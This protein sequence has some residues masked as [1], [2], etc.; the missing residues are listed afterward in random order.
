MKLIEDFDTL[1][2]QG[3]HILLGKNPS[4]TMKVLFDLDMCFAGRMRR[5]SANVCDGVHHSMCDIWIQS[6]A[7]LNVAYPFFI[8]TMS[9]WLMDRVPFYSSFDVQQKLLFVNEEE[10][11]MQFTEDEAEQFWN[12]LEVGVQRV[13]E[14]L[15]TNGWW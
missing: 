15:I 11:I 3:L 6:F 14:I 9:P 12:A 10:Q 2:T 5:T 7:E 4:R 1:F 13:S 8:S